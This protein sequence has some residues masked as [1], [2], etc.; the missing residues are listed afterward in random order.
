MLIIF[1]WR[2]RSKTLDTGVFFCPHC[3]GDRAYER[4]AARRW[5]T[6]FFLPVVPV[7]RELGQ[8]VECETCRKG[9]EPGVLTL[10]TTHG[11]QASR[12][13]ALREAVVWLLRSDHP[14]TSTT[15]DAALAELSTTADRPWTTTELEH[16][17]GTLDVSGLIPR[18]GKLAGGLSEQ[19]RESFL[20]SCT[21][22]AAADGP[23]DTDRRQ[24]LNSIAG[25]L[26]MTAAHAR[27]VID[28]TVEHQQR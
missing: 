26:L 11:L 17:L 5:F 8:F 1:G 10:P 13:T 15:V 6:L 14:S 16:D 28:Q 21:R 9:F 23:L 12:I 4:K 22:V 3:G 24:L 2:T 25:A 7:G 27:G 19:G 20:A 18:L